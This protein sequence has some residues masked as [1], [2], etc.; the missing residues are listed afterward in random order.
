M[1]D[2][3]CSRGTHSSNYDQIGR[4]SIPSRQRW[5]FENVPIDSQ[6]G[7][8]QP[9]VQGLCKD[10]CLLFIQSISASGS[11]R[12]KQS[13][14]RLPNQPANRLC[15]SDA[16]SIY[17][18]VNLCLPLSPHRYTGRAS[19]SIPFVE[20][21]SNLIHRFQYTCNMSAPPPNHSLPLEVRM[22]IYGNAFRSTLVDLTLLSSRKVP[23]W[24]AKLDTTGA[25]GGLLIW[26][27]YWRHVHLYVPGE[28]WYPLDDFDPLHAPRGASSIPSKYSG[29]LTAAQPWRKSMKRMLKFAQRLFCYPEQNPSDP[30]A[31]PKEFPH[32]ARL[33]DFNSPPQF[34]EFEIL[35][36]VDE[37]TF[38]LTISDGPEENLNMC[39]LLWLFKILKC[40]HVEN[41]HRLNIVVKWK[42][43]CYGLLDHPVLED[44]G[45]SENIYANKD[46]KTKAAI[47]F[48]LGIRERYMEVIEEGL[49]LW[50]A[51]LLEREKLVPMTKKQRATLSAISDTLPE[52][53]R[54]GSQAARDNVP[55]HK[56]VDWI[57]SGTY[58]NLQRQV[59]DA[60]DYSQ[61]AYVEFW[62]RVTLDLPPELTD[63]DENGPPWW[64][65]PP[66]FELYI[67]QLANSA[68]NSAMV[69]FAEN[70][71]SFVAKYNVQPESDTYFPNTPVC[72]W[73]LPWLAEL[74]EKSFVK[75]NDEFGGF[76]KKDDGFSGFF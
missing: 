30:N 25:L 23:E 48:G 54:I 66:E 14:H 34:I 38:G 44:E 24:V 39:A 8:K 53:T 61:R 11:T 5:F 74:R 33:R 62:Q 42:D 20:P 10:P 51:Y 29:P 13:L 31:S 65:V 32:P 12:P 73:N 19:R 37:D 46:E 41:R 18:V 28:T 69:D 57:A 50:T 16:A 63:H 72:T 59:F 3:C 2:G 15:M 21:L 7:C 40:N 58:T 1:N 4:N 60:D 9:A 76:V 55:P 27:H 17:S 68:D 67:N 43:A 47:P 22:L 71:K 6:I 45:A 26:Q 49:A 64:N 35:S 36:M 56:M 52:T 70:M 75:E